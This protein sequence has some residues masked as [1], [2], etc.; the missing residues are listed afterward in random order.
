VPTFVTFQVKLVP[1]GQVEMQA[2]MAPAPKAPEDQRKRPERSKLVPLTTS[3][4]SPG[5]SLQLPS[6]F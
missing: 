4:I 2:F 6:D 5:L 1:E 3:V